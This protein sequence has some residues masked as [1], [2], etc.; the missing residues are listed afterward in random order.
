MPC[1]YLSHKTPVVALNVTGVT[2][3]STQNSLGGSVMHARPLLVPLM[4]PSKMNLP[5]FCK[6]VVCALSEENAEMI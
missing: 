1:F 5:I 3:V 2:S 6:L 4:W